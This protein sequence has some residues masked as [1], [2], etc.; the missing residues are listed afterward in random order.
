[1]T[2][3]AEL[4]ALS[5]FSFLEG[6]S[7]PDEIVFEA[8]RLGD[9]AVAIADVNTLAGIVRGHAA[10]KKAGLSYVVAARLRFTCGAPDLLSYPTDRAAYGRLCKLLTRGK[11]AAKKGACHLTLDDALEH[12]E[13][14]LFALFPGEP[15]HQGLEDALAR[16]KSAFPDNLWLA[17]ARAFDGEDRARINHLAEIAAKA[18][19]PLLATNNVLY[20]RP[21]RRPLQ[22]VL[23][24]I[25]THQANAERHLK[26][27]AEMARLFAD[28]PAA[29]TETL[30]I[31]ERARF[32]LDILKYEYPDEVCG[33][34]RTPQEELVHLTMIGARARYPSGVPEKVRAALGY[35]LKLIASLSYAPYFLTVYDVVRAARTRG[36]LCQGRG[37]AA[38]SS[39]CYCLGV[40][41]VDPAQI[42]LLFERFVS[43]ERNEPPDI[44]VDFEHERREEV[45]Q[46]I[47]EK[48]GR[49]RAGIAATVITYRTRSAVREVGK[50]MG[51]SEDV[52]SALAKTV[53]G[54]TE[55]GILAP[56]VKELGL[57]PE[58][59]TIR[60]T[61][62]LAN[63]LIGFPRHLSQHSGGFVMTRGALEEVIPIGN[64][65]ME[66]RTFVEWDKD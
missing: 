62:R 21:E 58:D 28:H 63:E 10:G 25:R 43:A 34:G 36:I 30:T 29:I 42:D 48:Y 60:H 22:D 59:L 37:S 38:N 51:L 9:E 55:T 17:A 50:A 2:R 14:Q 18:R 53:W 15:D 49:H 40:T 33:E 35:E 65:A 56:Q 7:H 5:N 3:Y 57:D 45:I 64:A 24:C 32:S 13:G 47:Y 16:L 61:M 39:V 27:P 6:G 44:D 19:V 66:D 31:L 54:I 26:S 52:I 4:A 23:H 11:R 46:Y 1:M 41:S 20:H 8:A 12:G